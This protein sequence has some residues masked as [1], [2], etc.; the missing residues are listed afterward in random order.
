M[1]GWFLLF[2]CCVEFAELTANS[3]DPDQTPRSASSDLGLHCLP[4]TL[5]WYTSLKLVKDKI[6]FASLRQEGACNVCFR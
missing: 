3:V 6:E 2:S 4:V 5:L 1:S